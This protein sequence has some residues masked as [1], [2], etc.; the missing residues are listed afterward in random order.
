M[1]RVMLDGLDMTSDCAHDSPVCKWDKQRV[2]RISAY[3][4]KTTIKRCRMG[5]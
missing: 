2:R 5:A 3:S 1:L 4:D